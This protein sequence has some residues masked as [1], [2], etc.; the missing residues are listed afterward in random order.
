MVN[1]DLIAPFPS[2]VEVGNMYRRRAPL[3]GV[4]MNHEDAK[5]ERIPVG[6]GPSSLVESNNAVVH[7]PI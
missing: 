7:V 1:P 3:S 4:F 6:L 2:N 5:E